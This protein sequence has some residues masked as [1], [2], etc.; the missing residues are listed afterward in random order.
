MNILKQ[1][2]LAVT[3]MHFCIFSVGLYGSAIFWLAHTPLDTIVLT[4]GTLASVLGAG[5]THHWQNSL[6]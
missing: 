2:W 5:L 4:W 3:A 1:R 6:K